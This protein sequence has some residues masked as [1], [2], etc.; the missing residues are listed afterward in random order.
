MQTTKDRDGRGERSDT[1][2]RTEVLAQRGYPP[3][4]VNGHAPPELAELPLRQRRRREAGL[5]ELE[6][7]D[8]D[9]HRGT[10]DESDQGETQTADAEGRVC[11]ECSK[12]LPA[13]RQ[14]TCGPAC[15]KAHKARGAR[16]RNRVRRRP[17]P[18]ATAAATSRSSSSSSADVVTVS[19]TPAAPA[20]AA[21]SIALADELEACA[22]LLRRIA[23]RLIG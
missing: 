17:V 11:P 13:N 16:A 23:G 10:A 1:W 3:E 5:D 18:K 15:A 14:V 20:P 9:D 8:Q 7:S 22:T 12:P 21:R 4:I 6:D 19:P 2:T